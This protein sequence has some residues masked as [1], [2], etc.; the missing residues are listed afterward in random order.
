MKKKF[1][2]LLVAVLQVVGMAKAQHVGIKT[3]LIPDGFLS[4]NLGVEIGLARKW[5][6]DIT[7]QTCLWD[8]N[9]HKWKHWMAQPE[10]RLWLCDRFNGHFFGLHAIGGQYNFGNIHNNIHFLGSNFSG[11]TDYR[12]Q[13]WAAGAGIAYGY[14]WAVAK[15]WNIEAEIGIGW[16]HTKFDQYSCFDCGRKVAE[17]RHH[18]YY[19]PTKLSL[20]LEYIF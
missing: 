16:M 14:A 7:G 2:I 10:I 8:V 12:Y 9:R 19:G 6:L 4:P 11:L 1:L 15:H 18:N 5:S 17:D 3:N 20:A 13:G